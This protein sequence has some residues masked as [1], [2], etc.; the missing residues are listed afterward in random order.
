MAANAG[1]GFGLVTVVIAVAYIAV[2][3]VV[4]RPVISIAVPI[5]RVIAI[6]GPVRIVVII[7][8]R[9]WVAPGVVGIIA[10]VPSPDAPRGAYA[11]GV[12]AVPALRTA[13]LSPG[14]VVIVPVGINAVSGQE[15]WVVV[16]QIGIKRIVIIRCRRRAVETSDTR[17][18]LVRIVVV[19]VGITIVVVTAGNIARFPVLRIVAVGRR[20]AWSRRVCSRVVIEIVLCI[21]GSIQPQ[22]AECQ[23]YPKQRLIFLFR[24]VEC[25]F[26]SVP[27]R[28]FTGSKILPLRTFFG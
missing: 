15:V 27:V 10:A 3:V 12:P 4:V 23:D 20:N 26:A 5:V 19:L 22:G 24:D 16:V 9:P 14:P 21:S 1:V 11:P 2:I 7:V 18:V 28:K 25:F 8:D 13:P 17:R 6:P